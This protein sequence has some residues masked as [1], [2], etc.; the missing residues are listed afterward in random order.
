MIRRAE[1]VAFDV[2]PANLALNRIAEMEGQDF[3]KD[4]MMAARGHIDQNLA[5]SVELHGILQEES[6]KIT[7]KRMVPGGFRFPTLDSGGIIR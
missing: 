7:W 4:G 3:D 6:S 2:G 5:Q 1:G